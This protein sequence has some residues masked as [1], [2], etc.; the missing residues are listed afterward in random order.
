MT[1]ASKAKDVELE[2]MDWK[3]KFFAAVVALLAAECRA[4]AAEMEIERLTGRP[5]WWKR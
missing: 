2:A 5:P 3:H 4:E 1:P